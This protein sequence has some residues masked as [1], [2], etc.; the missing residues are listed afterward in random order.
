MTAPCRGGGRSDTVGEAEKAE[1]L[2][3]AHPL[4]G[5]L[6]TCRCQALGHGEDP[7]ALSGQSLNVRLETGPHTAIEGDHTL[8]PSPRRAAW[9]HDL[10]RKWQRRQHGSR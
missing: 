5:E 2:H 1:Q 4:V 7:H 10:G 8:G 3:L 9:Q 6:R